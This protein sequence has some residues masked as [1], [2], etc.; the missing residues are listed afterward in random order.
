MKEKEKEPEL[1]FE[2]ALEELKGIVEKL[3]RG[4]LE[5]EESLKMFERGVKLMAVCQKK[6][7][8]AERRVEIVSK[9]M[10]GGAVPFDEG[11]AEAD[12]DG[13]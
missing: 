10:K 1:K 13:K 12:D 4:D 8:D 5:L 9:G 2:K 3:E 7:E 11:A 6:L